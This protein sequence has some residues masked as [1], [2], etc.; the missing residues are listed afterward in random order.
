MCVLSAS[1]AGSANTVIAIWAVSIII[2]L[3]SNLAEC[4]QIGFENLLLLFAFLAVGLADLDDLTQGFRV[5]A[6]GF[7]LRV[8]VL[9][10]LGGFRLLDLA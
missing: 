3:P 9:Q 2:V 1:K 7:G 6:K 8:N 5:E 10:V 4:Q